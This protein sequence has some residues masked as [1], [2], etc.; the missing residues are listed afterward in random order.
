MK[1]HTNS[2]SKELWIY[3]FAGEDTLKG[4]IRNSSQVLGDSTGSREASHSKKSDS[5]RNRPFVFVHKTA[6]GAALGGK[7]NLTAF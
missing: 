3:I 4:K 2:C 5:R 7:V 1:R 6:S